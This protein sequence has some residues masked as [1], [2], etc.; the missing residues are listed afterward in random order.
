MA[1]GHVQLITS[2]SF[3]VDILG[4]TIICRYTTQY[5]S[6][7]IQ[8][9]AELGRFDCNCQSFLFQK[10]VS[11]DRWLLRFVIAWLLQ[12]EKH[13]IFS[14]FLYA[15]STYYLVKYESIIGITCTSITFMDL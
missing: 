7:G 13:T 2:N 10:C 11:C 8:S 12:I 4:Q 1:N 6:R 5:A 9:K 14:Q 3:T 15:A